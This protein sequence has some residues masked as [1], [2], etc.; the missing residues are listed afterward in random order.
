MTTRICITIVVEN[1]AHVAGLRGEHGLACW[2][3]ADEFRLLFDTGQTGEILRHNTER[4]S[5]PLEGTEAIALSHG[6]YDHTGGLDTALEMAPTAL[7]YA[8]PDAFQPR[9]AGIPGGP[10]R[11]IGIPGLSEEDVRR[12]CGKLCLSRGPVTIAEGVWLS[13]EIPRVTDFETVE[14]PFYLDPACK[15][16]DRLP[17]DQALVLEAA[18]GLVLLAGCAHSGII[19]ILRHVQN[20]RPGSP[21]QAVVGGFHLSGASRERLEKTVLALRE[22][23]VSRVVAGHCTGRDAVAYLSEKLGERAEPLTTGQKLEF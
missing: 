21:V 17:D 6:H 10:C 4:L 5:I 14:T 1:T 15:K 16:P 19:N 20:L 11:E 7:V 18:D 12:R 3:E 2:V 13:G 22:N 9:Y 23:N 8:H